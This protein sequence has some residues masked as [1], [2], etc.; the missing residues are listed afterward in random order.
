MKLKI[1]PK[2]KPSVTA[3]KRPAPKRLKTKPGRHGLYA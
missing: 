3:R 2:K 1:S